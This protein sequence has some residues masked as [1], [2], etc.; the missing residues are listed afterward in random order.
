M[1]LTQDENWTKTKKNWADQKLS[2]NLK[3]ISCKNLERSKKFLKIFIFSS[4][5]TIKKCFFFFLNLEKCNTPIPY[6]Q[7]PCKLVYS[8]SRKSISSLSLFFS[9]L[10]ADV[11]GYNS[12]TTRKGKN[13]WSLLKLVSFTFK[14]DLAIFP[15]IF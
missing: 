12:S 6:R 9:K 1:N 5:N 8:E 7:K 3:L 13:T 10:F 11:A 2:K 14:H 4:K 15:F